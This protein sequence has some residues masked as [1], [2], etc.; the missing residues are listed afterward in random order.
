MKSKPG[1]GMAIA[2]LLTCVLAGGLLLR[3]ATARAEVTADQVK[4]AVSKAINEIKNSQLPTGG[5]RDYTR[6]GGV[7][8]LNLLALLNA[9]VPANDPVVVKGL[10][11]LD[12]VANSDTYVVGLKSQ[13]YHYAGRGP[14]DKNYQDVVKWLLDAQLGS[15]TWGYNM[16][17]GAARSTIGD[18]SNSQF[19]LLG[20][21]EASKAGFEIPT[22]VWKLSEDLYVN[23]QLADGGWQYR[24][25]MGNRRQAAR[26]SM[27]CAGLASLY[28]T[29]NQL[30]VGRPST[31]PSRC[32]EYLQNDAIAKGLTWLD[33]FFSVEQHPNG[34]QSW[35]LY[36]LYAMERVGMISGLKFFG[37][38]DWYREGAEYL[39]R[40][41]RD[42][43]TWNNPVDTAFALLFLAKGNK[44]VIISKL[45]WSRDDAWSPVHYDCEH[46]VQYLTKARNEAGAPFSEQPLA[47]QVV[48]L[49]AKLVDLLDA[50]I[51][52][53]SGYDF[54]Q[55]TQAQRDKLKEYVDQGGTILAVACCGQMGF[56]V[57][58]ERF[59]EQTWP[60]YPLEELPDDHPIFGAFYKLDK[61]TRGLKGLQV[62]CRTSV[63]FS[64]KDLNCLWEKQDPKLPETEEAFRIGA[65]IC[66]YATG[67]ER[68]KDKLDRARVA[69]SDKDGDKPGDIVRGAL[70]I[71]VLKH[72][73][74]LLE[75]MTNPPALVKFGDFLR[76]QA[77]IDVVT[78]LQIIEPTDPE[79]LNHPIMYMTGH[80]GFKYSDDQVKAVRTWLDRGGFLFA[81]ACCGRDNANYQLPGDRKLINDFGAS[82]RE[83]VE[84]LYPTKDHPEWQLTRLPDDH[85]IRGGAPG[86]FPLA[87]V[88]YRPLLQAKLDKTDPAHS[89]DLQLEGV[90]VNGRLVIVYSRYSL[91][92]ELNEQKAFGSRGY[93]IK[94]AYRIA[95]NVILYALSN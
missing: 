23:S 14:G 94:D 90:V 6:A 55:F 66:A 5:W 2:A 82:F 89:H 45:R 88:S 24:A 63:I 40:S 49:Q 43:G 67:L 77:K 47:W 20:L 12:K 68:L 4:V 22:K 25:D 33:R 35:H 8:A 71:G 44:P 30:N 11:A 51:L 95:T 52:Y 83:F 69:E 41:Q 10:A 85:P 27:A 38:H 65:N 79:L 46:L 60:D 42:D 15:G 16:M 58:F 29:G 87:Q 92:V 7:T 74:R 80:D 36:Y 72:S 13:V 3:P 26:G 53:I 32:V 37:Q 21:H 57:G 54:P 31:N 78:R 50:P 19:A 62:G 17:K 75:N 34:P 39:V 56:K 91:T 86:Y 84:Q 73:P 76:D 1:A 18:N 59:A 9:G 61:N 81:S 70:H 93:T 48:N 64:P 28:I